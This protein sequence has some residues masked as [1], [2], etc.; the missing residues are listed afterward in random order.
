MTHRKDLNIGDYLIDDRTRNGASDFRD[1]SILF[2]SDKF[3]GWQIV[4]RY[5]NAKYRNS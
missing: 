1:E 3:S 4:Y 2:G 5:F